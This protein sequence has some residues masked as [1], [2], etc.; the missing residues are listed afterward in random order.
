MNSIHDP[1]YRG[2]IKR[3]RRARLERG[4]TQADAARALGWQRTM[5]SNIET[6]E[7]RADL[8]ETHL[9]CRLYGLRLS[10]LSAALVEGDECVAR[11][12]QHRRTQ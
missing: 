6:L 3:L 12:Q 1:R 9:L 11:D 10:D 7:R 8:L 4:M 5:L 2:T